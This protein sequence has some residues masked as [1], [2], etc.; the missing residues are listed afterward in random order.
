MTEEIPEPGL[1][2]RVLGAVL[3]LVMMIGTAV[4]YSLVR[5]VPR[6]SRDDLVG[7]AEWFY[8][9]C[10]RV[11]GLTIALLLHLRCPADSIGR[12]CCPRC[13]ARAQVLFEPPRHGFELRD[14]C[15]HLGGH[16]PLLVAPP[17]WWRGH[18]MQAVW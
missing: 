2:A 11:A 12:V 3:Y 14:G 15:W 16:F 13:R 6:A 8:D 5:L 7:A 1:L 17:G 10:V 4:L 9:T 18:V